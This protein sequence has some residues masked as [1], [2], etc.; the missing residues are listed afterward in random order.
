LWLTKAAAAELATAGLDGGPR[1]LWRAAH[2]GYRSLSPGARHVRTVT[3]DREARRLIVDDA[4]EGDGRHAC[5]LAFH[6]GPEIDCRLEG[7]V[8]EL[9]WE[10]EAG[11]WRAVMRLPNELDWSAVRG[12]TEPPLGWYSPCFGARLPI[13]TLLGQGVVAGGARLIT[14]LRIEL[15]SRRQERARHRMLVAEDAR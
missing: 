15:D 7:D 3:L 12:R 8:A 1:A 6:L 13:V 4:I 10:S 2:D 5:R 14:D 9:G 11:H